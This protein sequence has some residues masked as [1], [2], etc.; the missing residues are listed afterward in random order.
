MIIKYNKEELSRIIQ[1]ISTLT[2]ISISVLDNNRNVLANCSSGCDFCSVLQKNDAE[3]SLCAKSD[4]IILNLC[5]KTLKPEFHICRAGFYDC[6]MPI[7]KYDTITAFV[8][9]GRIR[10]DGSPKDLCYSPSDC[11][12]NSD[13][14]ALYASTPL[15]TQSQLTALYD[16]LPYILFGNAIQILHE[17]PLSDIIDYIDVNLQNPLS[18]AELCNR[19]HISKNT[20]YK[21]F[22]NSLN[23]GVNEYITKQR[24]NSAKDML[25][26]SDLTVFDI[27]EKVG[28]QN[29][30]YFCRLFK[31][32]CHYTPTEYRSKT[33]SK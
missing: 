1:N 9:M 11:K 22:K 12:T 16:L 13:L 21:L 3:H 5:A 30:T 24:L 10:S 23:T 18:V 14:S 4:K 19:F 8:I 29:Y 15:I 25:S 31:K 7:I 6:A 28:I 2:G 32:H 33:Q 17:K 20:L 26:A 27:A